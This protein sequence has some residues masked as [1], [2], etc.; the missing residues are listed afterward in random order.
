MDDQ[1]AKIARISREMELTW[2]P[3]Y[4]HLNQVITDRNL[5]IGVEIGVGFGGHVE[6]LLQATSLRKMYGIDPY[7][8]R[9]DYAD[10]MNLPQNDMD[11]LYAFTLN[12]LEVFGDR[13]E[14]LRLYSLDAVTSVPDGID[15]VYID[16]E[17]SFEGVWSDLCAWFPKVT[18]GGIV[19]GHDYGHV[20][21]PGV[22]KAVDEFFR[23]F[24]WVINE[25]GDGVWW[26]EKRPLN[27]SF[28][29]PA[30]NAQGTIRES[31]DS[32]IETNFMPGD[33]LIITDDASS[34]DTPALLHELQNQYAA[35]RI[36]QHKHNKGGAAAR[37]TAIEHAQNPILF[38]LDSDNLL[39]AGSIQPLKRFLITSGGD[40][41]AFQ[42]L[43]F[44][45][46]DCAQITHKWV[47]KA[48]QI[49]LA[50][51]LRTTVTPI[52]SGNYMFTRESWSRAGGYPEFAKALDAWGFGFR[53]LAT[54]SRLFVKGDS[55]YFHRVGHES[56]W[57]R[58]EK[59]SNVS[60]GVL[61]ILIPFLHR[62]EERDI[63]YITSRRHRY[64]WF[65]RLEKR[66]IRV[67][68]GP[69]DMGI[70]RSR[71]VK[72]R[73]LISL[74]RMGKSILRKARSRIG[75]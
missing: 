62:L 41:A 26:V 64:D 31:V 38:C 34:D 71:L 49:T 21:F 11:D 72:G 4:T 29:I 1:N 18:E 10:P 12:R 69:K 74:M 14:H 56:Y 52:S 35:I 2:K 75:M 58:F 50:D 46:E 61:Q 6:A 27:I 44:F 17:H 19:G 68:R 70:S 48:E 42:E 8:H 53:Q 60:L 73:T 65:E 15:F 43:R 23:R 25:V 57:T 54:G 22:K 28:F 36:V 24:D 32:I 13:Y 16:A 3:S 20:N 9:H 37:N 66:P 45:K 30:F 55:Y 51:A 59:Q 47:F 40:L 39:T 63:D 33:E 67:K 7:H 5:R